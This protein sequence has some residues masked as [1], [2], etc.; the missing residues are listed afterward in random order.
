MNQRIVT[1]LEGIH[2]NP[3]RYIPD[4]SITRLELYIVGYTHALCDVEA[5]IEKTDV[6]SDLLFSFQTKLR[7]ELHGT[8]VDTPGSMLLRACEGSE[9]RAYDLF[10]EYWGTHVKSHQLDLD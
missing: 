4:Q 8:G 10:W 1:L 5:E 9:R 3:N 6:N 7:S 2:A